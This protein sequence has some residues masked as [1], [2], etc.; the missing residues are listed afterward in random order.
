MKIIAIHGD[1]DEEDD[2]VLVVSLGN[3]VHI[4]H[5]QHISLS[6]AQL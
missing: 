2:V 4:L 5:L 6:L 1:D 3:L